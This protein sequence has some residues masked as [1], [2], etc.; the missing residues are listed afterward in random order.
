MKGDPGTQGATGI[1]GPD[2]PAS[3]PGSKGDTGETGIR[4]PR[5]WPGPPSNNTGALVPDTGT[6]LSPSISCILLDD[7]QCSVNNDAGSP[8]RR[9]TA[10][11]TLSVFNVIEYRPYSGA[12]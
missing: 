6:S 2:G 11:C 9:P 12:R 7:D 8:A 1:Q 3:N 4:G 5:G 10:V